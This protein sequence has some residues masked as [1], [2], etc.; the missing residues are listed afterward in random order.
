MTLPERKESFNT[1]SS[2]SKSAVEHI[3]D[4][5]HPEH[6]LRLFPILQDKAPEELEMLDRAVLRK[7]DWRFLPCI[8][9]MLLMRW[10]FIIYS[11]MFRM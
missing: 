8:T 9:M 5:P 11:C 1:I 7:L 6:F 2:T 10:V 4:T 3:E